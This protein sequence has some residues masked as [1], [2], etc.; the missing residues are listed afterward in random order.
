MKIGFCMVL[1]TCIKASNQWP[2]CKGTR[3]Q[4]SAGS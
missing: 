2:A 1:N 3:V 4:P